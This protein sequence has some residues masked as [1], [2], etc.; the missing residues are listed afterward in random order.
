MARNQFFE[1]FLA[2]T[3]NKQNIILYGDLNQINNPT[4]N[5]LPYSNP[6]NPGWTGLVRFTQ[7]L[8]IYDSVQSI[9][10]RIQNVT[11]LV[12]LN[13]SIK[14]VTIIDYTMISTH[15]KSWMDPPVSLA[16][17]MSGHNLVTTSICPPVTTPKFSTPK[18]IKIPFNVV[19]TTKIK[20][21][22]SNEKNNF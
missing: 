4:V 9:E 2:L 10:Y 5:I 22:I 6:Y 15:L 17:T 12:K 13:N 20:G 8:D 16:S 14:S 18:W 19:S 3:F 1:K 21:I 11:R 7:A